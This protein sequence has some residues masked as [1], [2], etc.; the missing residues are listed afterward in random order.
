VA[1]AISLASLYF[2]GLIS[3]YST[4]LNLLNKF[5][6]FWFIG[7]GVMLTWIG[8]CRVEAPFIILGQCFSTLYFLIIF[9]ILFIYIFSNKIF[10]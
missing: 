4:P 7:V 2:F 10:D 8:Q 6:V 5:I 1:F 9:V 3:N